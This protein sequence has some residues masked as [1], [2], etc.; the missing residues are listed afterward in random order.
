MKRKR[1]EVKDK[2]D[3]RRVKRFLVSK[4]IVNII[5]EFFNIKAY[6]HE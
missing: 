6:H 5:C 4:K 3:I 2:K 1:S